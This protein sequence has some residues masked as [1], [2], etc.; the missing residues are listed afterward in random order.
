LRDANWVEV[1]VGVDPDPAKRARS[2]TGRSAISEA[3]EPY[4][5]H[6]TYLNMIMDEGQE[7]V[8]A[9]YRQTTTAARSDQGDV[10]PE[11]VFNINQNILPAA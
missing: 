7:R 10:R 9:S 4:T 3:L 6:G 11:N 8:R 2:E 5:M 1:I